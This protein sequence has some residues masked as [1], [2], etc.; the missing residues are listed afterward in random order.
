MSERRQVKGLSTIHPV[1]WLE[2]LGLARHWGGMVVAGVLWFASLPFQSLSERPAGVVERDCWAVKRGFPQVAVGERVWDKVEKVKVVSSAVPATLRKANPVG[3]LDP[4]IFRTDATRKELESAIARRPLVAGQVLVRGDIASQSSARPGD[5]LR[6]LTVRLPARRA[7]LAEEVRQAGKVWFDRY[8][9]GT[10]DDA[11]VERFG[12]FKVTDVR[13]TGSL[14]E[15]CDVLITLEMSEDIVGSDPRFAD[16]MRQ[17]SAP[18]NDLHVVLLE[19]DH[20]VVNDGSGL[21]P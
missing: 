21:S 12:P 6:P 20:S 17:L 15:N 10:G 2:R 9:S 11:N 16:F 1:L 5:G 7:L 8:P 4:A 3:Y 14:F 13:R 18:E 19:N